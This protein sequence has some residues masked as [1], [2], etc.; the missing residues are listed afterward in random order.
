MQNDSVLS[1]RVVPD[2]SRTYN[3]K[4]RKTTFYRYT[5]DSFSLLPVV[6]LY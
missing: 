6:C 4:F 3:P 2:K 1:G 5:D